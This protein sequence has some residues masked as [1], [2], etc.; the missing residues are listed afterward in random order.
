MGYMIGGMALFNGL[1]LSNGRLSATAKQDK[2]H[3]IQI[4][5]KK[6][7]NTIRRLQ[8]VLFI[9]LLSV[10]MSP[11]EVG[12]PDKLIYSLFM[13]IALF[14][15]ALRYMPSLPILNYHGAE[16]KVVVAYR[17]QLPL[18]LEAV[19]PLSRITHLCGTMLVMPIFFY[20]FLLSIASL[21]TDNIW[22]HGFLNIGV[23]LSLCHYF[24]LR[25]EERA[26]VNFKRLFP[27]FKKYFKKDLYELKTNA[28]Y[29][30]FDRLG[31]FL[32]AYFTTREP[33]DRELKVALLC[34]Q[35]LLSRDP[36]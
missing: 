7:S 33:S 17:K 9:I 20:M 31:Y 4:K 16:H 19:R 11:N 5:I 35:G 26:Y 25:G 12:T 29:R 2:N 30:L 27:F 13:P 3:Q 34:M 22:L 1:K 21:F 24:F 23:L 28:L 10:A 6:T 18:T 8:I 15:L 14:M 36:A 32:Q